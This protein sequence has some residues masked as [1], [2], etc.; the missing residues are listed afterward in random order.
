MTETVRPSA[1]AGM[2][3]GV[4]AVPNPPAIDGL[5]FRRLV[6]PDDLTALSDLGNLCNAA[7]GV[8]ARS[9]PEDLANWYSPTSHFDPD[10]DI[11]L[12]DVDGQPI[13]MARA[14]WELDNDGG[15]DYA[16][17]G[18]VHRDWRRRGL[19]SAL[20]HW[21]E[22]RQRQVA[23]GHSLAIPKRMESWS[24][25]QEVGRNALLEVNGYAPVRYWFDMERP[26][27]EHIPD[28][29]L[30]DGFEFRPAREEDAREAW[31]VEIAAFRDHFGGMDQTEDAY[32]Q[33]LNEPNRD[34]SLWALV[35]HEGRIVGESLNRIK[36]AENE[37]LGVK[38]GW[39]IAVAVLADFRRRGLGRAIVAQS[40]RQLREAGM[41]SARLGVDAENPH[42]ALGIYEGLGFSVVERGRIYRKPLSPAPAHPEARGSSRRPAR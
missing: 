13:A 17:W 2:P 10:L 35:W 41:T 16:T 25:V 39:V 36:R 7:D 30:P 5:R 12:A 9:T 3:D 19:G 38:R 21:T 8:S 27:L 18:V 24:M 31:N 40:L 42:G 14:G 6:R 32:R 4:P 26:D 34:I 23:A 33:Q 11:L 20:L 29:S 37:A 22:A 28:S 1:V 15:H